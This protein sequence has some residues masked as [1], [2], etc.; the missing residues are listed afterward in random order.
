MHTHRIGRA[1][2]LQR[3]SG[4]EFVICLLRAPFLSWAEEEEFCPACYLREGFLF[5][6]SVQTVCCLAFTCAVLLKFWWLLLLFLWK[7]I[8]RVGT[9]LPP[10][11]EENCNLKK[12]ERAKEELINKCQSTLSF[13]YQLLASMSSRF[14]LHTMEMIYFL[15]KRSGLADIWGGEESESE[16][17]KKVWKCLE[18]FTVEMA[19]Q[20][21]GSRALG[22]LFNAVF[23]SSQAGWRR[24]IKSL[25]VCK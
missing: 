9:C 1:A 21:W 4:A 13:T 15:L 10:F 20:Y 6:E 24:S 19:N 8:P 11:T 2:G 16:R 18:L 5:N 25:S 23:L 3:E 17:G 14:Y 7:K 12:K 22:Q